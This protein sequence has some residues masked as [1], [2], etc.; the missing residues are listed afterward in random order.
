MKGSV[1]AR[2]DRWRGQV[3]IGRDPS[4]GRPKYRSKTFDS[5]PEAWK[6]VRSELHAMDEGTRIDPSKTT[7]GEHLIEWL[8]ACAKGSTS[9]KTAER[10]EEIIRTHLIPNLGKVPLSQLRPQDIQRYYTYARTRGRLA[11]NN[12]GKTGLSPRTVLHHHRLLHRALEQAVKW[13]LIIRN[14][15]DDVDPPK[16]ERTEHGFF[17]REEVAAILEAARDSLYYM[18]CVIAVSTGMRRGEILALRWT[19]CDMQRCVITVARSLEETRAGL[20][21]KEPKSGRKRRVPMVPALAGALKEH[22]QRERILAKELCRKPSELVI[23]DD[24]GKPLRPDYISDNFCSVL[25]RAGLPRKGFHTFRHTFAT[26][27]LQAGVPIK[28]LQEWLGHSTISITL[29]TYSHVM[30]SMHEDSSQRIA[31]IL[32][33]H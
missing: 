2:G 25:R 16:V 23:C 18:P 8:E 31:G 9:P 17:T 11:K 27:A 21:F 15:C 22:M 20:R 6:W 19:D 10:Y 3:Y 28:V 5:S 26:F 24:E 13:R 1:T 32:P 33:P 12:E 30:T 14:P 4:D 29:D 7:L